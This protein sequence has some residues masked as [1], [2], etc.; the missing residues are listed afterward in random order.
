[1]LKF[2]CLVLDHDDTIVQ[3]E[4]TIGYP[5]FRDYIA[6][7]RPGQTLPNGQIADPSTALAETLEALLGAHF[8]YSVEPFELSPFPYAGR[9]NVREDKGI[10]QLREYEYLHVGEC[11]R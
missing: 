11:D 7:I 1:M 8:A 10:H 9:K 4:R 6:R 2:K 3:T 5:Y